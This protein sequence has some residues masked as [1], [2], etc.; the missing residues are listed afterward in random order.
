MARLTVEDGRL[1]V[2]LSWW[3]HLVTGTRTVRVPVEAVRQVT[4]TPEPWRLLR[5]T[6]ERGLLL[7][8]RLCLGVWRHP[9]GRDLVALR[10]FGDTAVGVDLRPPVPFA[11]I[12]VHVDRAPQVVADLRTAMG[13]PSAAAATA[14]T[15]NAT[16]ATPTAATTAERDDEP[17]TP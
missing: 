16:G 2:R 1:V 12:A 7:P 6:R 8:G 14:A 17:G 9:V 13:E 15:A 3:E 11:R 4:R 5:G 10:P